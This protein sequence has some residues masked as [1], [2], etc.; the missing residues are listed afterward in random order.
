MSIIGIESVAYGVDD[1]ATCT[2]FFEDF[3]LPRMPG[4]PDVT[5]ALPDG[6]RVQ[7]LPAS[8]PRLP[9][10]WFEGPGMREV[11]FGV[12]DATA[13]EA[14]GEVLARDRGVE[15]M[16]DGSLTFVAEG[17]IPAR[18]RVFQRRPFE[19][20]PDPVNAPGK[21]QRLNQHRRWRT[22]ARPKTINHVVFRVPSPEA[23]AAFFRERLGFRLSDIS[24]GVGVFLRA[25][26]CS[27][28]HTLFLQQAL[29]MKG[30]EAGP[31]HV[32]FAVEDVDELMTGANHMQ[33]RGW[34]SELG[35]G[36]HRIASALFYYVES[37][38]GGRAEYGADTDYL[39]D[40]W[41]PRV[42]DAGFGLASWVSK[43]PGFL[44]TEPPWD[45]MFSGDY[46]PT[47]EPRT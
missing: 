26:G 3:G 23:S 14:L 32:C 25:D 40:S 24:R 17:G 5:F 30:F 2:R 20:A 9:R 39:D 22:R 41:V 33:R 36:R 4:A 35:L 42:W 46:V 28:H 15:R 38:C 29:P 27:E 11:C 18:L 19:C 21:V 45:V 37:P 43:I 34:R 16:A 8:D 13:L 10:S 44:Q 6:A 12:D 1:L 31:D 7:L 47:K